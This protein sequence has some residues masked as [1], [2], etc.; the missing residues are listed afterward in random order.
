MATA[1]EQTP[2]DRPGEDA[3]ILELEPAES[4]DSGLVEPVTLSN[5]TRPLGGGSS[6]SAELDALRRG[7]LYSAALILTLAYAILL[8][9]NL[10]TMRLGTW[11]YPGLMVL[12]LMIPAGAATLLGSGWS[13]TRRQLRAVEY[14]LFG[15][16]TVL[17]G[18]MQYLV[19]RDLL[20]RG[21]W[22][23]VVAYEKNGVLQLFGLMIIYGTLIPNRT[24]TA[25][26]VILSMTFAPL[27]AFAILT[28]DSVALQVADRI[29]PVEQ[30]GTNILYVLMGAGLAIYAAHLLHGLRSELHDA[31]QFG[32]YQLIRLIGS[33]G[34]G[35]VYLAEHSLLKR[36]CALKLIRN[37]SVSNPLARARFER[38]V[39]SAARLSHPNT[40]EVYD[41]GHSE[42]GT[43]FYVMEY[44]PG[45][46]LGELVQQF[47]PLP[48]GRLI[49][50]LRQA[51]RALAEAH[52]LGLVH[53]DL[54]PANIF[55]AVRGGEYDVV[56][57]LDFGL[58]KLTDPDAP[59]LTTDRTV[60][61][62]PMF[63]SPEQ[64]TG[65][66]KLDGRSDL[67]ALG[68]IA[69]YALTG[70]PPFE[71]DSPMSIMIAHARDPVVPPS[72]HAPEIP[73]DLEAIVLRC[74]AKS[75]EDRF[76]NARAVANAL[77]ACT[78]ASQWG[79]GRAEAWWTAT[80]EDILDRSR[81]PN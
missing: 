4:Y 26:R 7:R 12:R 20:L 65:S 71:G 47:G 27:L 16:L 77:A 29:R 81:P 36:P 79:D 72:T 11:L 15:C 68:A 28:E 42:D 70:R 73:A 53:R 9:W 76:P 5:D 39:Q 59:E 3:D 54:K 78:S 19:N 2:R 38:E 48:A 18:V 10:L 1:S 34:M 74:L 58:V 33:G 17:I 46:S 60:S 62:T 30:V 64:A 41:Y 51:C 31:R 52:A 45:M 75:P 44:L 57:I 6:L 23:S 8:V 49:Y 63:M 37:D 25:A 55:L 56:K 21:A 40:I 69:Y 35:E 32:H 67:Y 61:G 66:R 43:F 22:H 13:L 50:L 24:T 80:A 14:T